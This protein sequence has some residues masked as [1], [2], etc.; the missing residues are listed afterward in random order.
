[1]KLS[2]FGGTGFIGSNFLTLYKDNFK[3]PREGRKPLTKDILYLI[4]T[5]HNYHVYDNINLD[6]N[7]NLNILCEVLENCRN[8]DITIN[9]I[10]S[11]FV[12][13]KTKKMPAKETDRC[14]PTGFYSI[15]K[16]CAEDL[17][18]SFCKTFEVNYRIIRLCNI[19]GNNDKGASRKKNALIWLINCLK[20]DL[21]IDLYDNGDPIRDVLHVDDACAA[22][23]LIC[24]NSPKNEI[25]NVGS[26][27][28]TQIKT[29][30]ELAKK[31]LNSK[32]KINYIKAPS[33]HQLVQAKDFWMDVNKL[34][35]LGFT[36]KYNLDEIVTKL[37]I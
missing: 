16:K 17:L 5:I 11:W 10:S 24:N 6:V 7:T 13:G 3:I 33:F 12:Y 14:F 4:S 25:Y 30:I 35:N 36:E 27:Q 22:I 1:M 20:K 34:R 2:V 26:G 18:I 19:L 9:F 21:N 31:K 23:Q 37:C 8:K 29:I 28:P 15:T 32:S